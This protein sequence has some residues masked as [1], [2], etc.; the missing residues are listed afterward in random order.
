MPLSAELQ[1]IGLCGDA[2]IESG[3][4]PSMSELSEE[5]MDLANVCVLQNA[6]RFIYSSS[7]REILRA[8]ERSAGEWRVSRQQRHEQG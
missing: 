4:A 7:R 8:I 1:L 5:N 3:L 2:R 6:E